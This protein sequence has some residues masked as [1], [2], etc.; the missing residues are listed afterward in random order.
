MEVKIVKN[1]DEL[2]ANVEVSTK[3]CYLISPDG[4][5][6]EEYIINSGLN[7]KQLYTLKIAYN[8]KF[9]GYI[10][11]IST[12]K[13]LDV[14]SIYTVLEN[15]NYDY[16][17]TIRLIV[18]IPKN[19]DKNNFVDIIQQF[20]F[21]GYDDIDILTSKEL[22]NNNR[23]Q[24]FNMKKESLNN[25]IMDFE[26]EIYKYNTDNNVE[27]KKSKDEVLSHL[28]KVK[29]SINDIKNRKLKISVVALRNAGKSVIVNSFLGDEYAPTSEEDSTPNA[30]Y[31]EAWD[32]DYV[33]VKIEK[34]STL[35]KYQTET[36]KTFKTS[37]EVSEFLEKEFTEAN[38]SDEK[39]MPNVYI[40]YKG[41]LD[42]I[43]IDTPGPNKEGEHQNIMNEC[44]ED[45][46]AVIMAIEY[47]DNE[48]TQ[49]LALLEEV[50]STLSKKDK[51]HSLLVVANK[52]DRMYENKHSK[53]VVRYLDK[54]IRYLKRDKNIPVVMMPASAL[55]YFYLKQFCKI[56]KDKNIPIET[57]V[58]DELFKKSK[59]FEFTDPEI[60]IRKFV[61][62]LEE[63]LEE[64][65]GQC[66]ASLS[67][68]K[69]HSNMPDVISRIE[70]IA[71]KK[72]FEEIFANKF[73]QI[74][75][76]FTN[77]SNRFLVSKIKDLQDRRD[78][79]IAKLDTVE[80]FFED[81]KKELESKKDENTLKKDIE[82]LIHTAY[83]NVSQNTKD[84]VQD[85]INVAKIKI[86]NGEKDHVSK[87]EV[88]SDGY[89]FQTENFIN[90]AIDDINKSKNEYLSGLEF[91]VQNLDKEIQEKIKSQEFE[92]YDLNINLSELQP[93]LRQE[94]FHLDF[95]T[96]ENLQIDANIVHYAVEDVIST[97]EIEY[98][99]LAEGFFNKLK[100]S[101]Q[102]IKYLK[103]ILPKPEFEKKIKKEKYIDSEK[104]KRNL[105]K[106][107]DI[108]IN[109]LS[110]FIED[111]RKK[112]IDNLNKQLE[113]FDKKIQSDV[114]L[115][116]HSYEET[117]K[118]IKKMLNSDKSEI[119]EQ[120]K[121][122][123][124][125]QEKH[126]DIKKVIDVI[127]G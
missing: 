88:L 40:K 99:E 22:E 95:S 38:K 75:R 46:D 79:I 108:L 110:K 29:E 66:G 28:A 98:E 111:E 69:N 100:D 86:M 41:K 33:E 102:S 20:I 105:K 55:E 113:G 2:S 103:S 123:H 107:E 76:D 117:N 77:L 81:K 61:H 23:F 62:S 67:D 70:Y 51:I 37:T 118:N 85:V 74:D 115:I 104:V 71:K 15:L 119:E 92:K 65:H 97:K 73:Y 54:S 36:I 96:L 52:L 18:N 11:E 25:S 84:A 122:F 109:D 35:E 3:V 53:S 120:E 27:I 10:Q 43:I 112:S 7:A 44:L 21:L 91:G 94:Q 59:E 47:G 30:I 26:R 68:I 101:A 24:R 5:T 82:D 50:Q 9:K 17:D 58:F 124:S 42:Y 32:K 39:Y 1:K 87:G 49:A 60:T 14:D 127:I 80:Q 121:F 93:S 125:I 4:D 13:K 63:C 78:E 16:K 83:N 8:I 126:D 57:E 90:S 34:D 12:G 6:L 72:V 45:S 116:I 56:L 31:Y 89:I 106:V 114:L 19:N 48:E 64:F